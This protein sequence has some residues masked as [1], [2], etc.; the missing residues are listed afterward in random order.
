[1]GYLQIATTL[2]L[3]KI[4]Q[5]NLNQIRFSDMYVNLVHDSRCLFYIF[6]ADISCEFFIKIT[7]RMWTL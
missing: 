1:M 2:E 7:V 3:N 5:W 4:S 6:T